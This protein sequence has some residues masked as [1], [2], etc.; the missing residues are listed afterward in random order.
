MKD[1][2]LRFRP[3]V[4][5]LIRA[6]NLAEIKEL[7]RTFTLTPQLLDAFITEASHTGQLEILVWFLRQ[8]HNVPIS[9]KHSSSGS[10]YKDIWDLSRERLSVKYPHLRNLL[11]HFSFQESS[12]TETAGTDGSVIYFCPDFIIHTYQNTP[13][14]LEYFL[15]HT[16]CHCL[17]LHLVMEQPSDRLLWKT[18]CDTAVEQFF[19]HK[20]PPASPDEF[21]RKYTETSGQEE[22]SFS[23]F[24]DDH[25]FWNPVPTDD[26]LAEISLTLH[27]LS[28]SSGSGSYG[29]NSR[30]TSSGEQEDELS[31][32]DPG[33]HDFTHFLKA[34]AHP[35]EELQTDTASFDY[36]PYLYG[37]EHYGNIPMI[38]YLE[39][40][41]VNR[42]EE[43]VIAIDTSGSC[44][45]ET[46][47]RFM[48][49]TYSILSNHENF[50]RKMNVYIIQCD[51]F[52]QEVTHI[53]CETDW[54]N[55]MKNISIHGR[56]GTDFRPVFQYIEKLRTD[57]KLK[58]LKGLLYFTDG[59]GIYPESPTDYRTAF[60]FY[61]EKNLHQKIPDWAIRL[62]LDSKMEKNS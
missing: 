8:K 32:S 20:Y 49:E 62:T 15:L 47:R 57:R 38:E 61:N 53:T 58:K 41:E 44:S 10:L 27:S 2:K 7:C 17:F 55:Y 43:L 16:L 59:D 11:W 35:G 31:I 24:W 28:A 36:I 6:G 52:I 14:E 1:Q 33:T 37:L 51:S 34:F 42:L 40:K 18:A 4:M 12:Q 50:F 26:L 56:G 25:Q 19:Q 23:T 9:P 54:K 22:T 45:V 29:K 48:E 21:Y 39:Y 30:G 13:E 60:V 46:V 3:A 5:Q